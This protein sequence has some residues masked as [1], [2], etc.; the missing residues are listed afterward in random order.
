M[1][2]I[3]SQQSQDDLRRYLQVVS[4][5][6]WVV[7][8]CTLLGGLAAWLWST[9][10]D[11]QF[12]TTAEILLLSE[13]GASSSDQSE[14]RLANEISVIGGAEI[15][16]AVRQEAGDDLATVTA[17]SSPDADVI[18][19][20]SEGEDPA[21]LQRSV[22]AY[23][24][25]YRVS[26]RRAEVADL[27]QQLA[28]LNQQ[29][30]TAI[31]VVSA[32]AASRQ[33]IESQIAATAPGPEQQ[34]LLA[35]LSQL[36]AQTSEARAALLN[37]RAE[38]DAQ[39][40][41]LQE[42]IR[43]TTG[44]VRVLRRAT[45]PTTPFSPT[46]LQDTAVGLALGLLAGLAV[47]F[48]WD[49]LDDGI[50]TADDLRLVPHVPPLLGAVPPMR[51]RGSEGLMLAIEEGPLS[52]AAEAY[53]SV[54]SA[55]EFVLPAGVGTAVIT[56]SRPSEGKTTIVA[57][58]GVAFAEAGLAT[59]LVDCDLRRPALHQMFGLPVEDGLAQ[60]LSGKIDIS[61][62]RRGVVGRPGLDL[63]TAGGVPPNPAE[64]LHR[65]ALVEA[66]QKLSEAYEVV[67]MDAP[68]ALLAS[69][70]LVLAPVVGATVFVVDAASTSRRDTNRALQV[71]RSVNADPV[72]LVLNRVR[73]SKADRRS[74][75]TY[76]KNES[77][78]G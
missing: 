56:S 44:G 2:V 60:V 19:V 69:D 11:E 64:L 1:Q 54:A 55:L 75:R 48:L 5:R 43:T 68:P 3:E 31:D 21:T 25:A 78:S 52:P 70:V 47:A 53:R 57:N 4:R 7:I 34:A 12:R 24:D 37:V 30:Q 50:R 62:V 28:T 14:R 20:A 33:T 32:L 42:E 49:H 18:I 65:E 58:L 45:S 59:V 77:R 29:R 16:D 15:A 61:S 51:A 9:A 67:L 13:D 41:A 36:D 26:K 74:Y 76:S 39:V 63:V 17:S 10:Q 27:Q 22:N 6:R 66:V 73:P 40:S 71:L 8:V 38:Q 35:Q 72:G 23:V 46:P